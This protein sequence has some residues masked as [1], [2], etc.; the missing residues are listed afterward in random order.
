MGSTGA[1]NA[2]EFGNN[3]MMF[4]SG[5]DTVDVE[6]EPGFAGWYQ[7]GASGCGRLGPSGGFRYSC[8]KRQDT[9]WYIGGYQI[10]VSG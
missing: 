6:Y 10:M 4:A 3:M 8:S 2:F 1:Q 7:W 5:S 9:L